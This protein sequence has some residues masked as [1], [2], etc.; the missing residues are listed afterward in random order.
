MSFKQLLEKQK[1]YFATG[2]TKEV[3]FRIEQ[4]KRLR[5]AI[6]QNHRKVEDAL[7]RDIKKPV[8]E[9]FGTEVTGVLDE[10]NS[11]IEHLDAWTQPVEVDTPSAFG[12][13][14]SRIYF[15]PYGHVLI[16]GTW[17]YPFVLCLKPLIG[18]IAAGNCCIL[19]PSEISP[20]TSRVIA[21]LVRDCFNE[22]YCAVVECDAQA[23]SELLAE[24]FDFIHYTGSTRVGRIVAQAAASHLTPVV[25]EMGGKSPCLVDKTADLE[26]SVPSLCWGKFLNAGQTC[27]APDYL[28]VHKDIKEKLLELLKR[29]IR[30]FYGDDIRSN[31]DFGRIVNRQ[32]FDRLQALLT[33]GVIVCGGRTDESQLYI[34]PTIIDGVDWESKIMQEEIFG[35]LLPVITYDDLSEVI[36]ILAGREK[37]LALYLYAKDEEVWQRIIRDVPFGGGCINA[38][39]LHML[40]AHMPF[41]GVGNSGLGSYHG[42]WSIETFSHRKSILNKTLTPELSLFYPPYNDNVEILKQIY[43]V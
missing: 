25:L 5:R 16:I 21:E 2:E 27:V 31:G 20:N 22:S 43:L 32:H 26:L 11:A 40:N 10:L 36:R 24:R 28:L 3:G 39:I 35:P 30:T 38:A 14:Q 15:E 19:K 12:E 8:F 7:Y 1:T 41:G 37:P 33:E 9:A 29:Q 23:M 6:L 34:E 42:R 18:A 17:N 13:A 4:L